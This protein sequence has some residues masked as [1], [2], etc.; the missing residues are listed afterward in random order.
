MMRMRNWTVRR[1]WRSG[2]RRRG[3]RGWKEDGQ[4]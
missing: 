4:A 3:G 1:S 2:E